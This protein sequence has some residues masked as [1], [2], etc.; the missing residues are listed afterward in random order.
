MVVYMDRRLS[1]GSA[2][3]TSKYDQN[4]SRLIH[5]ILL[6]GEFIVLSKIIEKFTTTVNRVIV[7]RTMRASFLTV[8]VIKH[9]R[10]VHAMQGDIYSLES[11]V[12][13][14]RFHDRKVR[15]ETRRCEV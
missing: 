7:A 11:V 14:A 5:S 10:S 6:L 3:N 15:T 4:K 8:T 13:L 2:R 1:G 12:A 9:S